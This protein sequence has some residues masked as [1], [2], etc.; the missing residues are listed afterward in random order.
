MPY[1]QVAWGEEN[2]TITLDHI[3]HMQYTWMN[4]KYLHG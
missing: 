4:D 1:E 2:L 3:L